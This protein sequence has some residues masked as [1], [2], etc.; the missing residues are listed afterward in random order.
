MRWETAAF[1]AAR[2]STPTI[3][4]LGKSNSLET[5]VASTEGTEMFAKPFWKFVTLPPRKI[6]PLG[7][8]CLLYTSRC[9]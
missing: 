6:M 7:L 1:A 9:V 3:E 5:S 8:I 2:S 4:R